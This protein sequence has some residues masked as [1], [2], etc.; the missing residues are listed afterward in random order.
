[1]VL[2]LAMHRKNASQCSIHESLHLRDVSA[3]THHLL[4]DEEGTKHADYDDPVDV[5][6]LAD[7]GASFRTPGC[8]VQVNCT[9]THGTQ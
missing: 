9:D 7:G 8:H 5:A 1:M 2:P 4:S 6:G 3:M